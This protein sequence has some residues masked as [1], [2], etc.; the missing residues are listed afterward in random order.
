MIDPQIQANLWIK[1]LEAGKL[2]I[3]NQ[4]SDRFSSILIDSINYGKPVLV[5]N[6]GED[7]NPELDEI[8]S[9]H[10]GY[11]GYVRIGDKSAELTRDFNLYLTTKL[12]RPHYSPET[13]VKVVMVNFMTTEEGLLD[14][15]LALIVSIESVQTEISRQKCIVDNARCRRELKSYED[16]ILNAVSNAEGD[17]LENETLIS[18]L[19]LSKRATKDIGDQIEKQNSIQKN[20]DDTRKI[21]KH[22]AHRA[23][24]LFFV[25]AEMSMVETMYQYSLEWY[26]RIYTSAITDAEKPNNPTDRTRNIINAFTNSLYQ[27]VCRSLFEKDKLLFSFLMTIRIISGQDDKDHQAE[28]RFLMTGGTNT[29]ITK[30]NPSGGWLENKDWASILELSE[31]TSFNGFASEFITHIDEWKEVWESSDP[32]NAHWPGD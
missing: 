13:C 30:P 1:T 32:D 7:I 16:S 19:Q 21:Y 17:I 8:L 24:Q 20:I 2:I 5:E 22:V 12:S 6:V 26:Q 23:S 31:F 3:T 29:N 15:M 14:Q 11:E 9:C 10:K 27:N 4:A 28:V 18:T 25:V